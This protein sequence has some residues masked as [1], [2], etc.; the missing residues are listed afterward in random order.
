MHHSLSACFNAILASTVLSSGF[1][2]SCLN[3]TAAITGLVLNGVDR[4]NYSG[5]LVSGVGDI[6]G[7]GFHDVVVKVLNSQPIRAYV[8]FGGHDIDMLDGAHLDVVDGSSGFSILTGNS[9]GGIGSAA[10]AGDIN[11]DG[12]G[13]FVLGLP[14]SEVN[15]M[16]GVGKAVVIFGDIGIGSPGVLDLTELGESEG[17]AILGSDFSEECGYSV[18]GAG[19]VDGDGFDDVVVGAPLVYSGGVPYTGES[20]VVFGGADV[21]AAGDVIGSSLDG[22]NGF[23]LRSQTERDIL[24]HSVSGAGD[25]NGDGYDDVIV[26]A[27]RADPNGVRDAGQCYVV[28]GD[29]GV[30]N[31]GVIIPSS[32]NGQDG[33]AINGIEESHNLGHTVSRAGDV[34]GDGYSDLLVTGESPRVGE[35][36]VVFG[37]KNAGASGSV[38]ISSLNG[39]NG[40]TIIGDDSDIY[41]SDDWASPAGDINSDGYDDLIFGASRSNPNDIDQ[42]GQ[43]FVVFGGKDVGSSGLI[44]LATLIQPAGFVINGIDIQD[45]CGSSVSNAGDVNGDGID[46][47]IVGAPDADPLSPPQGRP[48]SEAG[49]IY[50]I[51]GG[52][53]VGRAISEDLDANGCVGASDLA[54][55][56][57]S[58]G[59]P[60]ADIDGDGIV[61]STDV[62]L[63][64]AAWR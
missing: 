24:G 58:W 40:F 17:F 63:L 8:V 44:Q 7:D 33:F 27:R 14:G 57:S 45:M 18:S 4:N 1:D 34:N 50:V 48:L 28:F 55:L 25:V 19:D 51:F 62:A 59:L 11:G 16:N 29:V 6:N 31:S 49:E 26:G 20:Y 56:L 2:L 39:L 12:I 61:D 5:H 46:D 36:Y 41:I 30:G 3:H 22:S 64:L 52:Q 60:D 37:G 15:G 13:D 47:V 35:I 38:E 23:V 32:L 9:V 42:A 54:I 43:C 53:S 21:G 10:S